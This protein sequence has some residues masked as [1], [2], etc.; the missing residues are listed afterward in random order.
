VTIEYTDETEMW[1][2]VSV[3]RFMSRA[4][5]IAFGADNADPELEDW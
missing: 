5:P 1:G 3:E 2:Q 4:I